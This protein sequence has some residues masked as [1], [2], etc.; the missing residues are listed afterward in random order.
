[1]SSGHLVLIAPVGLYKAR[2]WKAIV[3]SGANKIYLIKERKS[4]YDK[5]TSEIAK[6]FKKQIEEGLLRECDM[7]E[8]ADFTDLEDIYRVF[9]K[10]MEKERRK[11]PE[12]S[13]MIDITS[14]TKEG[15]LVAGSIA[16]LWGARVVYVP[17]AIKTKATLDELRSIYEEQ[18]KDKG[19]D[20]SEVRIPQ[21]PF[22]KAV[23]SDFEKKVLGKILELCRRQEEGKSVQ[24]KQIMNEL[25]P[26]YSS[27]EEKEAFVKRCYRCID[28]L[29]GKGLVQIEGAG[30]RKRVTL[31]LAGRGIARGLEESGWF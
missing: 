2:L 19:L 1:V 23:L 14:T 6:E 11:N 12:A 9:T 25:F 18:T 13:F 29:A 7:D 10:I 28:V 27:E 15:A 17:S 24:I 21:V 4:E 30:R 3:R 26:H 31:T 5:I 16:A 20:F 22:K 8:S